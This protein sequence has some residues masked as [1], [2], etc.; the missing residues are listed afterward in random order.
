VG[1]ASWETH[2]EHVFEQKVNLACR[3]SPWLLKVLHLSIDS[4]SVKLIN[5]REE[6]KKSRFRDNSNKLVRVN[7]RAFLRHGPY[8]ID[9]NSNAVQLADFRCKR[10]E[11]PKDNEPRDGDCWAKLHHSHFLFLLDQRFAI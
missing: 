10:C 5:C 2:A 4:R 3:H 6:R 1:W 8:T 7:T 11:C 9:N